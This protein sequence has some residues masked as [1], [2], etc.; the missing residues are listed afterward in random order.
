M[1][2]LE[3]FLTITFLIAGSSC[4]VDFSGRFS[5]QFTE[6]G[7]CEDGSGGSVTFTTEWNIDDQGDVLNISTPG[8][9]GVIQ[10]DAKGNRAAL[11]TKTC[12]TVTDDKGRTATLR[13]N[14]GSATLE[15]NTL[16]VLIDGDT[17]LGG[18]TKGF[19]T[20]TATGTMVRAK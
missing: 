11:R 16:T 10:A 8:T 12:A 19:C 15:G 3:G 14:T 1:R 7:G 20:S 9:C 2:T 4:G 5:G 13:I 18:T 17:T 6:K